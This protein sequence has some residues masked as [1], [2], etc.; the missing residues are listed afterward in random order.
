MAREIKSFAIAFLV[1]LISAGSVS[2]QYGETPFVPEYSFGAEVD[3]VN[4]YVWRGLDLSNDLN[5]QPSIW[6]SNG[7]VEVGS[8]GSH[9]LDGDYHEQDFWV[10]YHLARG[11]GGNML[12]RL[13]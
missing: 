1:L 12:L 8:W 7:A 10:A 6:A 3:G 9:A 2:A 4:R 13:T 11:P 5:V